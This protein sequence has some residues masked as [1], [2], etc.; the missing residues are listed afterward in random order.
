MSAEDKKRHAN[1]MEAYDAELSQITSPE[2]SQTQES[3]E[4]VDAETANAE[5]EELAERQGR[6]KT[7]KLT[8]KLLS[9]GKEVEPKTTKSQKLSLETSLETNILQVRPAQVWTTRP[10]RVSPCVIWPTHTNCTR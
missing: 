4:C 1:E 7:T 9:S 3:P 10:F 6:K 2:L 8:K 5:T